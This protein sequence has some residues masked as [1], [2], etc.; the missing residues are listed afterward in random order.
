MHRERNANGRSRPDPDVQIET[1]SAGAPLCHP[2]KKGAATFAAF[3][4]P[5]RQ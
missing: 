2:A 4:V 3:C 5:I 1:P